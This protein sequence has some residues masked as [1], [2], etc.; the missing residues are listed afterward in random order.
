M[1]EVD[2]FLTYLLKKSQNGYNIS[3]EAIRHLYSEIS[4]L[5]DENGKRPTKNI[6]S[7]NPWH[8]QT[9]QDRE[10]EIN[11][12]KS[13]QNEEFKS[14]SFGSED[15]SQE[16][17][18]S[19]TMSFSLSD[20]QIDQKDDCAKITNLFIDKLSKFL[21][22]WSKSLFDL[23]HKYI[24]DRLFNW[25]EYQ[26]I[27]GEYLFYCL[28]RKGFSVESSL[29]TVISQALKH[30]YT[31]NS[32]D[33]MVLQKEL[34]IKG[35]PIVCPDSFKKLSGSEIR[36]M[37]R[38]IKLL[39]KQ[40]LALKDFIGNDMIKSIEIKSKNSSADYDVVAKDEFI[41][42]LEDKDLIKD[43][44]TTSDSEISSKYSRFLFPIIL[45]STHE[46]NDRLQISFTFVTFEEDRRMN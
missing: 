8:L 40:N 13:E 26:L 15:N 31:P 28:K 12:S 33:A 16:S 25:V 10:S 45:Y 32:I 2:P 36:I 14:E 43:E 27:D 1:T 34:E 18:I 21:Q 7:T 11:S 41:K 46:L 17:E 30:Q 42:L 6:N 37:N 44:E 19:I 38:L 9:I 5:I 29:Q 35:A 22:S 23:I 39:N 3:G 4:R 20:I 24:Y